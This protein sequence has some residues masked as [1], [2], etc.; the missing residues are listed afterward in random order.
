M[1]TY[2]HEGEKGRVDFTREEILLDQK[3]NIYQMGWSAEFGQHH[4]SVSPK[5]KFLCKES[6]GEN[7]LSY[8]VSVF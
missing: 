2:G 6:V 8:V 1:E 5:L 4:F 7:M 3:N